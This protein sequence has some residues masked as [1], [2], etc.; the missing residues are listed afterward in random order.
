MRGFSI[1]IG[2]SLRHQKS[3]HVRR[4]K[5]IY[6]YGLVGGWKAYGRSNTEDPATREILPDYSGNGR[7]IRLYNFAF[8]GMSGYGGYALPPDKLIER[9][10]TK[11]LTVTPFGIDV[12]LSP[13]KEGEVASVYC[14]YIRTS[15]LVVGIP[16]RIKAGSYGARVYVEGSRP[17]PS[18]HILKLSEGET[19]EFTISQADIDAGYSLVYVGPLVNMNFGESTTITFLPTYPGG[20]VSD[21]VDDYVRC[22]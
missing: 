1:G 20:L 19:G 17:L 16:V 4:T 2:N 14:T 10:V 8:S 13:K 12:T 7:D 5:A 21:G 9:T 11:E 6:S 22:V 18:N 3:R 15:D